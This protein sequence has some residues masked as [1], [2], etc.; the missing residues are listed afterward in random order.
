MCYPQQ[1]MVSLSASE[2]SAIRYPGFWRFSVSKTLYLGTLVVQLGERT[3]PPQAP[4]DGL[5]V[6]SGFFYQCQLLRQLMLS[7][8]LLY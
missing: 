8:T 2:L 4:Q 7:C 3:D 5:C 6:L 1:V